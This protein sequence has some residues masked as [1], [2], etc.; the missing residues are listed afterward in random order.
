MKLP[1]QK[2][3]PPDNIA[4]YILM[5]V[6]EKK[7]GKT[8]FCAQFP[9][10]FIMEFEPGNAKHLKAN[11]E[12]VGSLATFDSLLKELEKNP[13]Y[14]KTLI[15]DEITILYDLIHRKL[16]KMEAIE[17]PGQLGFGKGWGRIGRTFD[18]YIT[19]LQSLG[20]GIIYTGHSEI[21][22]AETR[23]GRKISKLEAAMG[24][25]VSKT[26]DRLTQFWGVMQFDEHGGRNMHITGDDYLKA[27]H[28]FSENH[29]KLVND[30][31]IPLGSSPVEAYQNFIKAWN[32]ESL[33]S[34]SP[35]KQQTK[36]KGLKINRRK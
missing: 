28:G 24:G 33:D 5:I 6:G 1:T 14:C 4:D 34:T 31:I 12:D 20:C 35:A 11:Y 23:S 22:E 3:I 21:K 29:F 9:D 2:K 25:R 26:M 7:I 19:R 17:D 15:L 8:S 10:H 13:G 16:L 32:N 27:G 36:K 30:G 18:N